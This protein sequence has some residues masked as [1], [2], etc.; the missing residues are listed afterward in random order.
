MTS[1]FE[2]IRAAL[3]RARRLAQNHRRGGLA[4]LWQLA[5]SALEERSTAWVRAQ[6]GSGLAGGD[7]GDDC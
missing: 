2:T 5:G 1:D 6:M 4:E 7:G 3:R